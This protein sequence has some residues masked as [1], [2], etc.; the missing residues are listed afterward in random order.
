M[1]DIFIVSDLKK[2]Q[3]FGDLVCLLALSSRPTRV[4]CPSPVFMWRWRQIQSSKLFF[5][6]LR[7]WTLSKIPVLSSL[8]STHF[9]HAFSYHILGQLKKMW[10]HTALF[11]VC[12]HFWQSSQPAEGFPLL[13]I[14]G[15]HI[16]CTVFDPL[17]FAIVYV[18]FFPLHA[19]LHQCIMS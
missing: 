14:S 13:L 19:C 12:S 18:I 11:Y 16:P 8:S 10:T 1:F 9:V 6:S 2:P 5:L 7:W 4:G 17:L 3:N 15:S